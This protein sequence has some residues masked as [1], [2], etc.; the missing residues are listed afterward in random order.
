MGSALASVLSK[1][2]FAYSELLCRHRREPALPESEWEQIFNNIPDSVAILDDQHRIVRVNQAMAKRLGCSTAQCAGMRCYEV[3]HGTKT[4]PADCPHLKTCRDHTGHS[5]EMYEPCLGGDLSVSTTPRFDERG[6]FLG[7][8]HIVR[9]ISDRKRAQEALREKERQRIMTA[10][11][12]AERERFNKVLDALPAYVILLGLDYSVTFANHFFEERFGKAAGRC[13]YEYLFNRNEPCEN[14]QSYKTL[15]T[16]VPQRWEWKGPDGRDYDIYDFPFSDVN[17]SP[18][19]LEV[20]LDITDTKKV[21]RELTRHRERLEELV[22]ERTARLESANA[23]LQIEIAERKQ[24]EEALK[25]IDHRKDEF[26]AMLAHE[27]RNPM[28][29]IGAAANLLLRPSLKPEKVEAA[30]VALKQRVT[31]MARLVDDLLD[32]SRISRGAIELKKENVELEAVIARAVEAARAH[33]E[34]RGQELIVRVSDKLPIFGDPV[35]LEQIVMNLLTNASRYSEKGQQIDLLAYREGG[36]AVVRVRDRGVG[37]SPELLPRIFEPFSQ[38]ERTIARER[39]GLG[40]GLTI[41]KR[42]CELHSGSVCARS[43]GEGKGSEFEIRLPAGTGYSIADENEKHMQ[44]AE[45]P[46]RILLVEDHADTAFMQASILEL[47]GHV[48][49]TANNGPSAVEMAV[50][51]KPDVMLLDIGLPGFDG[52]EVARRVRNAGLTDMVIIAIS[53][54]GQTRDVI[55]AHE[56]GIDHHLLKPVEDEK[57]RALLSGTRER[58]HSAVFDA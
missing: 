31:Q 16:G 38:G 33:F 4:P 22:E 40:L 48:L 14:C 50:K 56:A 9:D 34:E 6:K 37:I 49:E 45:A 23:Q 51:M 27:L 46:L 55:R 30:K 15:Q 42:L 54:Y 13:C 39:G 52:Y 36:E 35:R 58:K 3:V 10:A 24:A 17:G 8:I 18:F 53:G 41:V 20:G 43:D 5:S 26:L 12:R 25:N 11:A 47:E 2:K 44:A 29:A 21:Q 7:S 19:I 57:L 28:A 32:I 1:L